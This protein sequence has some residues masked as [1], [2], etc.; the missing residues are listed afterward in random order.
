MEKLNI[1]ESI[2]VKMDASKTWEII[3]PN[4]LN[5][6]DWGRGVLKSW[7]NESAPKNFE[8]APA[9]GR[10]CEVAGF[11]KLEEN[12]IH[13]NGGKYEISWSAMGEKLPKFVSGLQN[14]L[15]VEEIDENTC[16]ITSNLTANLGGLMGFLLGF[17]LKKNFTKLIHGFLN[18]GRLMLKQERFLRQKKE[19]LKNSR[20]KYKTKLSKTQTALKRSLTGS[21]G[22]TKGNINAKRPN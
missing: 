10:Y 15:K 12:I 20:N 8:N 1:K 11:G 13:Y 22:T 16:K 19:R 6:S 21:L 18:D 5:I 17:M 2:K 14:E 4:F 7:E 9:G 3:G